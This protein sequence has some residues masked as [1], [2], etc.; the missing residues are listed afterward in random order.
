MTGLK[1]GAS[2]MP[3]RLPTQMPAGGGGGGGG[4]PVTSQERR[5]RSH[6]TRRDWSCA[7]RAAISAMRMETDG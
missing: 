2:A 5:C 3:R 4:P 7:L 6:Q 1:F